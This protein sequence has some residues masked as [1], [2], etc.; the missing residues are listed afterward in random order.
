[1]EVTKIPFPPTVD[2]DQCEHEFYDGTCMT[3]GFEKS[4]QFT[5]C[6]K[7]TEKVTKSVHKSILNDLEKLNFPENVCIKANQIYSEIITSNKGSRTK[8][9]QFYC[10]YNACKELGIVEDITKL[11]AKFSIKKENI[12]KVLKRF[13]TPNNSYQPQQIQYSPNDMLKLYLESFDEKEIGLNDREE[14][15]KTGEGIVSRHEDILL[16][17]DPKK[18]AGA[19]ILYYSNS[20]NFLVDKKKLALI[21]GLSDV[22]ITNAYRNLLE[23]E[24]S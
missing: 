19:I 16:E 9:L 13:N 15:I 24:N 18:I 21:V 17:E 3:C 23:L 2:F 10:A 11:A 7:S 8:I 4:I 6:T 22:T 20:R 1:M 5:G 14:I 12:Q